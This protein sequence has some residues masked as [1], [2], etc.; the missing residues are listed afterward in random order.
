MD[1]LSVKNFQKV[2]PERFQNGISW[3]TGKARLVR[4]EAENKSSR[5]EVQAQKQQGYK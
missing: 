5:A 3:V 4:Q 1:D 2:S